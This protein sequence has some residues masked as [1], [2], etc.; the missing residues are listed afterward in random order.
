M[1]SNA[2]QEIN[3]I[4]DRHWWFLGRKQIIE[5]ILNSYL[6][7]NGKFSKSIDIGCGPGVNLALLQKFTDEVCGLDN[8]DEAVRLAKQ[9]YPSAEIL[10]GDL[11]SYES[12]SKYELVTLLDVLE[13]IENDNLA[14]KKIEDL[15]LPGGV[16]LITVPAFKIFWS[17]HDERFGHY[18]RYTINELKRKICNS[19]SLQIKKISYFNFF[20]FLPI[21][22]FRLVKK[23]SRRDSQSEF[24]ILPAPLNYILMQIFSTETLLLPLMDLP[25]GVSIIC[26][27]TKA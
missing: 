5:R 3:L 17:A 22:L 23:I 1:E 8:S 18:R 21:L 26:V 11:L 24:F 13:H 7:Q 4:Q 19:T 16:A 2:Y 27:L 25:F 20:L 15:L 6:P 14:L 12:N 9:N 10:K